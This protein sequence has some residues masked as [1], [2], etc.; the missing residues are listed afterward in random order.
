MELEV[1]RIE[2][3]KVFDDYLAEMTDED[4]T[5]E[6]NLSEEEEEGLASLKKRVAAGELVV[7][8]T[9]KSGRFALMTME[10]YKFSGSKHTMA[11]RE[12]DLDY[13]RKNQ[14]IL[15]AHCSMLIKVFLIGS[16]WEHED[17]IRETFIQNS[18]TVCPFYLL[19]KDHK[20]WEGHMGG[21]PPSRGIAGASS[22][23]NSP[24][25]EIIS[26]VVE[27]IVTAAKYGFEKI[28]SAD[29]LSMCDQLNDQIRQ[30]NVAESEVELN[31]TS[32]ANKTLDGELFESDTRKPDCDKTV[33]LDVDVDK[34]RRGKCPP[35]PVGPDS[36]QTNNNEDL[37][38]QP[39]I[40][41]QGA[42]ADEMNKSEETGDVVGGA[43]DDLKGKN[44]SIRAQRMKSVR[45]SMAEMR[46]TIETRK[47]ELGVV[48]VACTRRGAGLLK[49]SN[50][51]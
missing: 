45:K 15:N 43:D 47:L 4:G 35:L 29:F 13:V 33:R 2:W 16:N 3:T 27:P 5:Q 23:Q 40:I 36:K 21:P 30:N 9:D 34:Q 50:V 49:S 39:V 51:K 41:E 19:F 18:L 14:R 10:D 22:G 26:I 44:K 42:T 20:G 38:A 25:S 7:C 48:R 8:A 37:T 1:K 32:G 17:R 11:D 12:V 24:L 6:S 46:K 28:S 31:D